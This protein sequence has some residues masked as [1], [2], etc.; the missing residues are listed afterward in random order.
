MGLRE[1]LLG[2]YAPLY[3]TYRRLRRPERRG[4]LRILL[5]HH[6]PAEYHE[7]FGALLDLVA[8]QWGIV[9]PDEAASFIDGRSDWEGPRFVL[10]FDDAFSTDMDVATEVLG[11]RGIKAVFF[12]C[13][14]FIG[15][16]GAEMRE[17]IINNIFAGNTDITGGLRAMGWDDIRHLRDNG[18]TIGSHGMS[19]ARLSEL[20]G[21][22]RLKA[23]V[24]GSA[25]AIEEKLGS[26]V[27]WFAYPF[28]DA[29]S[30]GPKA[31]S[32]VR[33]RYRYCCT[34]L[35]GSNSPGSVKHYLDRDTI[36]LSDSGT[37]YLYRDSIQ[38][39]DPARHLWMMITGG[40]DFMYSSKMA[41]LKR[42]TRVE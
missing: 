32:M 26:E 22:D 39:S 27:Q 42:R 24:L 36:R 28:G 12:I 11:P 38:L 1:F 23:E 37:H 4:S 5:L 14:K 33:E 6:L 2:A 41:E 25:E 8:D 7:K 13:P 16:G 29:E 34:G 31:Y 15:L 40:L 19:H 18:H 10:S 17:F 3:E 9:S 21:G 20:E 30:I 35:R